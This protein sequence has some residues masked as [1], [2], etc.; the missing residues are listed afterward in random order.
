MSSISKAPTPRLHIQG[1]NGLGRR[2]DLSSLLLVVLGQT[3]GLQPLRLGILL[4]VIAAEQIHL[5]VIIL[6]GGRCLGRV[7][8]E[9]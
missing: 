7:G 2:L 1:D 6:G 9:F 3:L 5:V 8:R 4:L